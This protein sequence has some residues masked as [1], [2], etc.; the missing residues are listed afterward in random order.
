M[1]QNE[2]CYVN[3]FELSVSFLNS[4][5]SHTAPAGPNGS[6]NSSLWNCTLYVYI[7][8]YIYIYIYVYIYMYIFIYIYRCMYIFIYI[9]LYVCTYLYLFIFLY[10]CIQ[11]YMYLVAVVCEA[12]R[13][14]FGEAFQGPATVFAEKSVSQ[15]AS[16]SVHM[17]VKAS[18]TVCLLHCH[19]IIVLSHNLVLGMY[20]V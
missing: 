3:W 18:R 17:P 16:F 14:L 1:C 2:T 15:N 12:A 5:S 9:Y 6:R 20:L 19:C 4:K 13:V 10:S 8:I 7:C 11:I